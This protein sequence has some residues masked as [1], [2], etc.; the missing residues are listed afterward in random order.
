MIYTLCLTGIQR[1]SVIK[2]KNVILGGGSSFMDF[3]SKEKNMEEEKTLDFFDAYSNLA[4]ALQGKK[5]Q[6][7]VMIDVR[8]LSTISDVFLIATATSTI[9]MRTLLETAI[10][11]LDQQGWPYRIEGENSTRWNLVDAGH[12]VIHIF[13]KE[14][15]DYYRLER[16]WGDAPCKWIPNSEM[17]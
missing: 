1:E 12:V 17:D 3:N 8:S 13:S 6:D 4:T 5:G 15:R 16:L 11:A 7:I 10:E 2:N 14:A 9:N